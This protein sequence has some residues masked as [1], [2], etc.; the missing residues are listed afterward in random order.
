MEQEI[1]NK[2]YEAVYTSGGRYYLSIDE[3]RE[4]EKRDCHRTPM[5]SCIFLCAKR[6][7]LIV[8]AARTS[9]AVARTSRDSR[10][11]QDFIADAAADPATKMRIRFLCGPINLADSQSLFHS[12]MNSSVCVIA[13]APDVVSIYTRNVTHKS[14]LVCLN[15]YNI[16]KEFVGNTFFTF[17]ICYIFYIKG[18]Y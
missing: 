14:F 7:A 2:M 11:E 3:E 15:Y 13:I 1:S 17:F 9:E 16:T 8:T 5:S 6:A 12:S 10:L 4:K 18:I